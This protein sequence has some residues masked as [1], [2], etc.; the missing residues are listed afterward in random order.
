MGGI[1]GWVQLWFLE[2]IVSEG[3]DFEWILNSREPT[4]TDKGPLNPLLSG[5]ESSRGFGRAIPF[6]LPA[7]S[8]NS[9][10]EVVFWGVVQC[11][12]EKQHYVR[13]QVIWGK[14]K[15]KKNN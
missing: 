5:A 3:A 1:T 9:P 13:G 2:S 4:R 12:L 7:A 14:N 8:F 11:I 15:I 10:I 6:G